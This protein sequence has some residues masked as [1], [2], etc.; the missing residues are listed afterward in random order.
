MLDIK[1]IRENIQVVKKLDSTETSREGSIALQKTC[2]PKSSR[3]LE[4]DSQLLL[5]SKQAL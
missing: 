5:C 2:H 4:S 1:F 3:V